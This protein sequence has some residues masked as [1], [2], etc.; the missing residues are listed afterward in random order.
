M[1]KGFHLSDHSFRINAQ[2]KNQKIREYPSSK[3]K[4]KRINGEML[5]INHII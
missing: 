5:V 4:K 1:L 3:P 2:A